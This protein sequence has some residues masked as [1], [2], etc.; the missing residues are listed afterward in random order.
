MFACFPHRNMLSLTCGVFAA[1]VAFE[2]GVAPAV[3]VGEPAPVPT[4]TE[5]ED[6]Q[7]TLVTIGP[8][9]LV[10]QRDKMPF[11]M[12]SS[13]STL[14]RNNKTWF[15]YHSVDWGNSIE[16]YWGTVSNPFHTKVWHK[17]RDDLF[18]LNGWYTDI[19]HAGL[20]LTNIH[21]MND[22]HL[23]GVTHIEL[24]YQKP[25]V[26]HGEDYAIGIVHSS[27]GGD[28]WTF[29]GEIVRPK[30]SKRNIGGTP[31]LAVGD[32]FHVYFND[33]G[34]DGRQLAVCARR[35]PT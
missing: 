15:F 25:K 19:H 17:N 30:N 8:R 22:G 10:R 2:C 12:D 29:C 1:I 6:R 34:P 26:N 16:K 23:L 18:D 27:D 5:A 7:T 31:L 20:W 21:R 33:H 24:H 35:S 4:L 28:R 9:E 3:E 11:T 13:L 32:Y 14:R